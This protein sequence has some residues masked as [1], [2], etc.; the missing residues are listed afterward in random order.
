MAP[1]ESLHQPSQHLSLP[2]LLQS[3]LHGLLPLNPSGPGPIWPIHISLLLLRDSMLAQEQFSS[4]ALPE[5]LN[6]L[7]DLTD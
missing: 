1:Y 5:I 7:E 4:P 2:V 3:A 6:F